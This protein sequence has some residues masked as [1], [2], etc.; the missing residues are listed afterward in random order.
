MNR[1]VFPG[2]SVVI[3][4]VLLVTM[5]TATGLV[6]AT[7]LAP[8]SPDLTCED[9][10]QISQQEC[11]AL[12][13]FY[14]S[15]NGAEWG[16]WFSTNTPCDDWDG[17]SCWL[18][19]DS[20][21]WLLLWDQGIRGSI[22]PELGTLSAPSAIQLGGNHL[23]GSIPWQI[24]NL[25]SLIGLD[26]SRNEL[27]GDIPATIT[28]LTQLNTDDTVPVP[29]DLGYNGLSAS[30]PA[31]LEFLSHKDADWDQTQTVRP[32]DLA[33]ETQSATAVQLTW[34]P[35]SYTDHGGYYEIICGTNVG[36][37]P[38]Y[39]GQTSDKSVDSYLVDGL[40]PDTQYFFQLRTFTPRHV[41]E[42]QKN[43]LYSGYTG[44]AIVTT[45]KV[46]YGLGLEH[47][48]SGLDP[49]AAPVG[50][51]GCPEG[52]YKPGVDVTLSAMPSLGWSVSGWSGT[53]DDGS[54][55]LT[56]T[57]TTIAGDHIATVHYAEDA[58]SCYDLTL[59][60]TGS[61][62]DPT[63]SPSLSWGCLQGQY[64]AGTV[65]DL[66]AMPSLGWRISGWNGT[67]DDD[68]TGLYN[69]LIMP[70]SHHYVTVHYVEDTGLCH[71]LT[72]THSGEGDDP[73]ASPIRSWG[74][75]EGRYKVGASLTLNAR[76]EFGCRV[77]SWS[78]TD[79]DTR[80]DLTNHL[81]MPDENHT[82]AVHYQR[83]SPLP[84]G[85][86]Y[87]LALDHAGPG[88]DPIASPAYSTGCAE[89]YYM[90]G[91]VISLTAVPAPG[92]VTLGW[93][94]TDDDASTAPSNTL[95]MP[96][97]NRAVSVRYGHRTYMPFI[98]R[99]ND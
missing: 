8:T 30:D 35:I 25:T 24:G 4:I 82:V 94:G 76:P 72:L 64:R 92:T 21:M 26:L 73:T 90:T 43:D 86:C 11:L 47:S 38:A 1:Y 32:T 95:T 46:C 69:T 17:V 13:A 20:I 83:V 50:S 34:T 58:G 80:L 77:A 45:D 85:V 9:I 55:A 53:D 52:E 79:D 31:V 19:D 2:S 84:P 63:A 27:D 10:T 98:L 74:C 7:G 75:P 44:W 78:G 59:A 88:E 57:L 67:M 6:T 89:G 3:G 65:V 37:A 29:T 71:T 23:T 40:N 56:N 12:Q 33:A 16:N 22:P 49:T 15:T 68:S 81:T 62:V 28:N 39:C 99:S 54:T 14:D 36:E 66:S 96:N 91:Q 41:E 42:Y 18:G 87:I 48:G 61:G 97:A 60:H 70:S 5:P 51:W 93:S